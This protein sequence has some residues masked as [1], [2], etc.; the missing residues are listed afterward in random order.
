MKKL[1]IFCCLFALFIANVC[2]PKEQYINGKDIVLSN[3]MQFITE[4]EGF[5]TTAYHDS[6]G[7]LTIGVG[8]VI[9][10]SEWKLRKATL[11]KEQVLEILRQDIKSCEIV[12]QESIRVPI[13]NFQQKALYS[14]CFNIGPDNFRQSTVT[15]KLNQFNYT[16]AANAMLLWNKPAILEHRRRVERELFL[17]GRKA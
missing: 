16:G 13:S 12:I 10:P 15:K 3:H 7:Y 6:K 5:R 1:V 8:H 4:L 17:T 14:F 9:K 11:S 2:I